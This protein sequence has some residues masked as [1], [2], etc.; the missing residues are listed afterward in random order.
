MGCAP[1]LIKTY[2]ESEEISKNTPLECILI[3]SSEKFGGKIS[4][5]RVDGFIIEQGPDS[6]ISQKP[7]AVAL[8]KKL[9]RTIRAGDRGEFEKLRERLRSQEPFSEDDILITP[10]KNQANFDD[11]F[12]VGGGSRSSFWNNLLSSILN[13]KLLIC[14]QSEFGAALGVARLAMFADKN[15][16]DTN[17]II[18]DIAIK[19]TYYPN[20]KIISI[21]EKR[22]QSWKE[23]YQNNKKN[24]F[25]IKF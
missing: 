8:C 13:K 4:T 10:D 12:M 18:K 21:L 11:I 14:D 3:E 7:E 15:I 6:F 5:I 9:V 16:S 20:E 24:N 22:Y 23:I 17:S 1:R 19:N 2:D 25:N